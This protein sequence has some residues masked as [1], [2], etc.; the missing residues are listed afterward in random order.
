[1]DNFDNRSRLDDTGL[2]EPRKTQAHEDVKHIATNSITD[3]HVSMSFLDNRNS[4]ETVRNTDTSSN[5]GETHDCVRNT[6]GESNDSDHPY[7]DITVQAD[8]GDRDEER[9][10]KPNP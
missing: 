3:G 9:E 4:R 5:E 10:N 6:K 7:H 1:M 2:E 8:P